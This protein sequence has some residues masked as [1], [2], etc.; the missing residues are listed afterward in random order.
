MENH[1]NQTTA[2]IEVRDL[3]MAYDK[4]CDSARYQFHCEKG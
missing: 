1:A 3:T 4:L 2:H